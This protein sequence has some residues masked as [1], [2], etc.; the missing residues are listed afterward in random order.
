MRKGHFSSAAYGAAATLLLSALSAFGQTNFN[1]LYNFRGG[2]DAAAP[3]AAPILDRSG[4]VYGTANGVKSW[5]TLYKLTRQVDGDWT[6]TVLHRWYGYGDNISGGLVAGPHGNMYGTVNGRYGPLFELAASGR[7]KQYVL[8]VG[9]S[10]ATLLMDA[11]GNLYGPGRGDVFKLTRNSQGWKQK[12]IHHF[13]CGGADGC[14]PVGTLVSDAQGNLYGA[15]MDGGIYPPMCDSGGRGC[16]TVYE[17][18]RAADGRWKERI[19]HRFA[20]FKNDGELPIGGPV[21]DAKGNLYGTTAQGGSVRN[22]GQC[23]VGCGVIYELSPDAK[24]WKETILYS[25]CQAEGCTDGAGGVALVPDGVGNFYG[26]AGGGIGPCDNGCGVVFKLSHEMNGKWSYHVLHRF[27]GPDG[28]HPYGG[29]TLDG[30]G[31]L[32]GTTFWGGKYLYGVVYEITP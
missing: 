8:P 17:L 19:L 26:V 18:L 31:S 16:G 13:Q 12:V 11:A 1:V 30:K 22:S 6:E 23:L 4:N 27:S 29:V 10:L 5:G 3:T 28:G 32:Y 7:V 15:T 21:M 9:G 2:T 25:F 20:Q 24:G 14:D